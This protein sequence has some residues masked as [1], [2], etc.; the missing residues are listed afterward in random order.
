MLPVFALF[1][2][3]L[4]SI[5]FFGY[6]HYVR[7]GLMLDQLKSSNSD[8]IP[9]QLR[10]HEK[11][12]S[13]SPVAK[14]L[15]PIGNLLPVSPQDIA[16]AKRDLIAA[17]F[18]SPSAVAVF[19]GFK[20]T[21]AVVCLVLALFA[22]DKMANPLHRVILPIAGAGLG[23]LAPAFV[24][25]RAVR[26][27]HKTLR[28]SL[29][30][31]L[32]LMVIC[33]EAGSGLDQAILNVSRELKSVH[34]VLSE[35]LSMVNMEIMAGTTRADALRNLARRVG[36]D[37]INKLVAILIQTDRFGTSVAE[38]LRTQSQFL[39]IRRKQAAEEKAGKVGVK[40]VFPI[41]FFCL[42]AL[43]V[44]TAGPGLLQLFANLSSLR[45]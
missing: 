28:H 8:A 1:L 30:D 9:L 4:A 18:R 44:V 41:F 16:I 22:R 33:T 31:V 38:A 12:N 42:P 45:P 36:E 17:G 25:G 14:L 32:D 6:K 10:Q 23:F 40:L 39:R 21:L 43:V 35:E 2:F 15:E 3:L 34:P 20:I 5:T 11:E 7:P 29:P 37:E 19:Y 13:K 26:K 27:R 24:L